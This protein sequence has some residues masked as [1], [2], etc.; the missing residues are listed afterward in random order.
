MMFNPRLGITIGDPSGVG[1]ETIVKA[2]Q[3][4]QVHAACRPFVIGSSDVLRRA[5]DLLGAEFTVVTVDAV[6]QIND[7]PTTLPCLEIESKTAAQAPPARCDPRGGQAAYEAVVLAARL[8]Q[9][10]QIDGIV[11]APLNKAAL[12][13]AGH[14]YPGHTELLADC[15]EAENTAM[16]LYLEKETEDHSGSSEAWG[17][18][19]TTLHMAMR[20]IFK[21]LSTKRIVR[22]AALADWAIRTLKTLPENQSPRIGVCAL[23]PHAGEDG[24]F[25]DEEQQIIAPAVAAALREGLNVSGP[26]PADSLVAQADRGAFDVLVAMYHDQGHIPLKLL[27]MHR[28]VNITLGLPI[29]RTSASHGTAFDRAW[30]G[31]AD[32]DGMIAAIRLAAKLTRHRDCSSV[33]ASEGG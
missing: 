10:Q 3:S 15:C 17:V 16:M 26:F 28:A 2:W 20:D 21:H 8:A 6:T 12:Q 23:N 13:A 7:D 27:G 32:A 24:L 31:I 14:Q 33:G 25:G 11:T 19:H 30:Q 4:P 1:P 22:C 18:V 29:V 9:T 5:V